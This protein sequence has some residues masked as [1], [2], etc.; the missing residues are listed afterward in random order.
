MIDNFS[1]ID[2]GG[3]GGGGAGGRDIMA[4]ATEGMQ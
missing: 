3:R 1:G 4:F 2:T